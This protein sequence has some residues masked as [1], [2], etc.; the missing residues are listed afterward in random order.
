MVALGL[1]VN[2]DPLQLIIA[3]DSNQP[4]DSEDKTFEDWIVKQLPNFDKLQLIVCFLQD[5]NACQYRQV[6]GSHCFV[7][8]HLIR[9]A[10]RSCQCSQL[11]IFGDSKRGVPS[12]CLSIDKVL[13]QG[14]NPQYYALVLS[15]LLSGFFAILT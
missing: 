10:E 14:K 11:K 2:A 9:I 5:K 4:K 8:T 12:Q 15:H 3:S 1:T 7:F 6:R 13:S